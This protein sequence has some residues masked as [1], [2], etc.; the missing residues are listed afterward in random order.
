[1]ILLLIM[2]RSK[3][4]V[5]LDGRATVEEVVAV[6]NS[7]VANAWYDAHSRNRKIVIAT[8]RELPFP[9][10]GSL[11][12]PNWGR[13]CLK[14]NA[15]SLTASSVKRVACS[16]RLLST[17][18]TLLRWWIALTRSWTVRMGSV[19]TRCV[20]S[21]E[22]WREAVFELAT[23]EFKGIHFGCDLSDVLSYVIVRG[24]EQSRIVST[25]KHFMQL[26]LQLVP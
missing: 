21:A 17:P 19:P 7:P 15:R 23:A 3:R 14:W 12:V 16:T 13:S 5:P 11:S 26:G 24:L 25:D 6:L 2:G 8:L 18:P 22:Q 10:F 1:M 9:R 20:V 4:I